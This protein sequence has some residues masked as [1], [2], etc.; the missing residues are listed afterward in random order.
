LHLS[1]GTVRNRLGH[2]FPKL[3]VTN[4][5]QAAARAVELSLVTPHDA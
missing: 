4:R 1:P 5:A 3:D 2:L